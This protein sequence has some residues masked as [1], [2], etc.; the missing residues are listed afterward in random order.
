MAFL[1]PVIPCI[2]FPGILAIPGM[3]FD[4]LQGVDD[5]ALTFSRFLSGTSSCSLLVG[6]LCSFDDSIEILLGCISRHKYGG[7]FDGLV[8]GINHLMHLPGFHP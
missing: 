8:T 7:Q 5:I 3:Y 2:L 1:T 4:E 6:I